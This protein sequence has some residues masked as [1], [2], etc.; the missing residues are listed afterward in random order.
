[1]TYLK[2]LI[3]RD[4]KRLES[5]LDSAQMEYAN[6]FQSAQEAVDDQKKYCEQLKEL[7]ASLRKL[8]T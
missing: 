1:M 5:Y 4:I 2:E 8:E 3:E 6:Y 7:Y